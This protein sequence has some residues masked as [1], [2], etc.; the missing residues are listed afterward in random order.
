MCVCV[1]YFLS[2]GDVL[3]RKRQR[4]IKIEEG[5]LDD[6]V[7]SS[8]ERVQD[9]VDVGR[10]LRW[11]TRRREDASHFLSDVINDALAGCKGINKSAHRLNPCAPFPQ[12]WTLPDNKTVQDSSP[13]GGHNR[14]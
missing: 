3:G 10:I 1:Q 11:K 8:D 14:I 9:A 2:S 6:V 5:Q 12:Q 7:L 4:Q 13:G